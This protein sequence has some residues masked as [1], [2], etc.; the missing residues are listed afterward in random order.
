MRRDGDPEPL[1]TLQR[2]LD[3]IERR[4]AGSP[5]RSQ[6]LLLKQAGDLCASVGERR[7]AL[8][9]YGRA[10]NIHLELGE[11]PR[12]AALC[13]TILT[14]H[15][16]AVRARCT[17]AWL[18]LAGGRSME[19]RKMVDEYAAAARASGQNA[20]AAQQLAWM[21]EA[22]DDTLLRRDIIRAVRSLGDEALATTLSTQRARAEPLDHDALWT[23]V[24]H[25]TLAPPPG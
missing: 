24:L 4:L 14:V 18:A 19:T 11:A 23:R 25:G 3:D 21:Y 1:E 16:E 15:P 10:V 17:L 6:S 13:H 2:E 8:A 22:A 9:W 12:A 5:P 7:R 20:M